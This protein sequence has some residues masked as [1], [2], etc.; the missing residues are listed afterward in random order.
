[1]DWSDI[2]RILK[3]AT[4]TP[5]ESLVTLVTRECLSEVEQVVRDLRK[6]L[7]REQQRVPLGRVQQ[8]DAHCLRWLSRQPGRD[9]AEKAGGRQRIL[10]VVRRESFDTL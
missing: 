9:A 3:P 1:M 8:V 5:E 6:V 10:A 7:V 2:E 4:M